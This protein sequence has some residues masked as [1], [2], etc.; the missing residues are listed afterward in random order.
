MKHGVPKG[1]KKRKKEIANE[2]AQLEADLNYKHEKELEEFTKDNGEDVNTIESKINDLSINH[3]QINENN[4]QFNFNNGIKYNKLK[5]TK[6]QKRR[7]KKDNKRREQQ[8]R[9]A[10]EE[11][12][13][14]R[15]DLRKIEQEKM[16]LILEERNL[17]LHEV[18][19]DGD[20]MY[21]AIEHQLGLQ[22][23]TTTITELR[24]NTA[25]FLR[26]HENE[27]LPFLTSS[28]TGELMD[29][30]EFEEYCNDVS[31]TKLWGGQ[32]ELKA[33]SHIFSIPIEVIQADG[34][35][36]VFGEYKLKESLLLR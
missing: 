11:Q 6:A 5:V 30:N 7:E 22:G 26:Q 15:I 29:H 36:I 28:K 21:K 33:L 16:K 24:S 14:D 8:E 9:I 32:I 4:D 13:D 23:I 35:S 12:D 25:Q 1:D 2:I 3:V 17:E 27:F 10:Q 18:P 20:C 31:M 34:P 19:S